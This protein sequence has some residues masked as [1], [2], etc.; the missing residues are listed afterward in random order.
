M[1]DDL[2]MGRVRA[3]SSLWHP[4]HEGGVHLLERG[5][6]PAGQDMVTDDEDLPFDAAFPGG[7]VGGERVTRGLAEAPR[8][9][10]A[11]GAAPLVLA[12][13]AG[14]GDLVAT[15]SS[16]PLR[17]HTF[18]AHRRRGLSVEEARAQTKQTAEGV[19]SCKVISDL[20]QRHQVE[21]P[22]TETVVDIIHNGR[23]L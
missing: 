13:L 7:T 2:V 18:G 16:T 10:I 21:L 5:E 19:A 9:A 4:G 12:G 14:M 1:L 6:G 11:R 3:S 22:I 15:Y 20:G 8:L 17:N 23:N